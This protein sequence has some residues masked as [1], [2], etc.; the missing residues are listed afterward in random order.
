MPGD[1]KEKPPATDASAAAAIEEDDEPDECGYSAQ[2]AQMEDFKECWKRHG[3]VER[4]STK[5]N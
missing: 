5:D 3:N 1:V 4:T 2:D